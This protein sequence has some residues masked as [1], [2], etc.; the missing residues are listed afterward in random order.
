[1]T[2]Q[3]KSGRHIHARI[4]QEALAR[5]PRFYNSSFSETLSEVL[6]NARRS[7]ATAVAIRTDPTGTVTV[8][9]NGSGI[10]DPQTLLWFGHS[11]WPEDIRQGECAAGMGVYALTRCTPTIRSRT[12]DA[13]GN[14]GAGW[15]VELNEDHFT[16]KAAAAVV[17]DDTAPSPHGTAVTFCIPQASL[18]GLQTSVEQETRYYPVLTTLDGQAV[19]Q[20]NYL[21]DRYTRTW[22]GLRFGVHRSTEYDDLNFYG[23]RIREA[24]LPYVK[25]IYGNPWHVRVDVVGPTDLELTLPARNDVVEGPFASRMRTEA[26]RRIYQAMK[27][28]EGPPVAISWE[29]KQRAA[30]LGVT[31]AGAAPELPQ[32]R[33]RSARGHWYDDTD[34]DRGTVRPV[35]EDTL[36]MD[37]GLA[38]ADSQ[39]LARAVSGTPL[40]DRLR[41]PHK[42]LCGYAWFD[43]LTRVQGIRTEVRSGN[44]L[45]VRRNDEP[46]PDEGPPPR[47]ADEITLVLETEGRAG[48]QEIRVHAGVAFWNTEEEESEPREVRILVAQGAAVGRE[49]IEGML[50]EGFFSPTEDAESDSYDTQLESFRGEAAA[51]AVEALGKPEDGVRTLIEQAV[52]THIVPIVPELSEG[53]LVTVRVTQDPR[54]KV[55][56]STSTS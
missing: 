11:A 21:T 39:T 34:R 24:G 16:G 27:A 44:T 41:E 55:E 5:V 7:G 23:K 48:K 26:L 22:E 36:V 14:P 8:E 31:L 10:R 20:A 35:N 17:D 51:A 37:A 38:A 4:D 50:E 46:A 33:P 54:V 45:S 1:M 43:T 29:D 2:A 25:P 49:E 53:Q 15:A 9:D 52:W 12:A 13:E 18:Q 30:S 3:A 19:E 40:A 47:A 32:W 56:I 6:Q 42:E 28:A